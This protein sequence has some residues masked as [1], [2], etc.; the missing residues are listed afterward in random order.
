M[1][2]RAVFLDRDGVLNHN[3]LNEATGEWEGPHRQEDLQL[4]PW[5]I[6]SLRK[7][8][9]ADLHLFLI[10]NQPSYAK[11]KATFESLTATHAKLHNML[12]D[13]K[14]YFS[15]YFYCYHHPKG[16]VPELTIKCQCRKP[17]TFFIEKAAKEHSLDLNDSVDP[18][19]VSSSGW[20]KSR[21]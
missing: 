5:T 17:G 20:L 7:L 16:I 12:T 4:Y 18:P 1:I 19:I 21:M 8:Q 2:D 13:N 6:A 3:V 14:I 15:D 11:G 10:S 9:D